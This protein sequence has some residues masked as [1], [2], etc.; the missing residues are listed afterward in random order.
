VNYRDMV[1]I[2]RDRVRDLMA[3][4]LTLAQIQ[5]A[6]PAQGYARAFGAESG[7][8][9]TNMFIEAIYRTSTRSAR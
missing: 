2:I 5:A 7:E 4:G 3:Q 9:T 6:S 1:V 8:W